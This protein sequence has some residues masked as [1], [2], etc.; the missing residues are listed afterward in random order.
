MA[1]ESGLAQ[2]GLLLLGLMLAVVAVVGFVLFRPKGNAPS[3]D[4]QLPEL[5]ALA[6]PNPGAGFPG[7]LNWGAVAFLGKNLPSSPGW[8]VRYNATQTLARRGSAQM[9]LDVL[10]EMLDEDQ[11]LR[12]FRVRLAD[13]KEVANE[14]AARQTV[15]DALKA[16]GDWHKH[17]AVVQAVGNNPD[18][19]RVYA[20][21]DKLT[22]N[23]NAVLRKEAESV[24]KTITSH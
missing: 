12:N 6:V 7:D 18:L 17:K 10:A 11:Q 2:R 24:K 14:S 20:A 23:P 8:L 19:Q 21:I 13:G 9:P 4:G 1:Q 5:L 15:F 16:V 3:E 22:Q